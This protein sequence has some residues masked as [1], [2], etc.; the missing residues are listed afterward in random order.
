MTSPVPDDTTVTRRTWI[1]AGVLSVVI[2]L[3]GVGIAFA[4]LA[5]RGPSAKQT[6]SYTPVTATET[7]AATSRTTSATSTAPTSL[8]TPTT[9]E[10]ATSTTSTPPGQIVRSALIAY[11]LGGK[12]YVAN[13]DGTGDM[14]VADS[15]SGAFSLSPDG[16]TLAIMEGATT[17]TD[18]AVLID[19]FTQVRAPLTSA[20]ELP[21]WSPDSSWV[22]YTA[23]DSSAK[24]YTIH[25]V[26]RDGSQDSVVITSAADAQ[27]SPDGKRIAHTVLPLAQSS[28]QTISVW[29]VD[30]RTTRMAPDSRGVA[31]FAFAPSGALYF[32][33]TG[34]ARA[35][36]SVAP[37]LSQSYLV[38]SLASG[39]E[40]QTP[41]R[42]FPSPDGSKIL[43]SMTGDD[44]YSR[45]AVADTANKK[46]TMIS[47]RLDQ[48][49]MGWL[50]D[51]SAI[52]YVEGNA[53]QTQATS[54]LRM[55]ADG[56]HRT[57]IK[58]GA[59]L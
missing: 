13:E 25:R 27:I 16:R 6:A 38:A 56:T 2:A 7:S 20:V 41:G 26:N 18:H 33:T 5:L 59:S 50:L 23:W 1:I 8:T 35:L 42:L 14:A 54:L 11:R 49:P 55:H 3:L 12:V 39:T 21:A 17:E 45:V 30:A 4:V 57:L 58:S 34:T 46:I 31:S 40:A 48:T 44:G 28:T 19:V 10:E 36:R 43:F 9:S 37:A 24:H 52:I 32:T 29:D 47:A 22:A 15:A 51:G 53:Y